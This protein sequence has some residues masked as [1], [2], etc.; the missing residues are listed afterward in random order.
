MTLYTYSTPALVASELRATQDFSATTI[1]SLTD[2]NTW[3]NQE[4]A[5]IN[6]LAGRIFGETPYS[7][8]YDYN[9]SDILLTKNAPIMSVT[10]LLYST[11]A[12]GTTTY[13]LTATKTEDTDFTAYLES[14]EIEILPGWSPQCG[15]KRIQINYTAG[16]T[17]TPSDIEMLAT[18]K[19]TKRVLDTLLSKDVNEKQSGKSVSVGSISIVKPADF[20]VS[21]YKTLR[22][23]V[24]KMEHD[25]INGTTLY[26]LPM[27]RF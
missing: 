12:L 23:D 16:Y 1:P 22:Q 11:S 15:N 19:L 27:T 3:I 7:E 8:T 10:S 4:S 21:Q 24:D 18:K 14:G 5:S 25:L 17:T 6:T 26:R 20:G 13:G 2:I 9:G